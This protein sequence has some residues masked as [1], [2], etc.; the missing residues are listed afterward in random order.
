MPIVC[1]KFHNI[2]GRLVSY[3]C[4][5]GDYL[6]GCKWV[7]VGLV[8]GC[9]RYVIVIIIWPIWLDTSGGGGIVS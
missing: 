2:Q 3:L 8:V 7:R 4:V 5:G 1:A 6:R 9:N